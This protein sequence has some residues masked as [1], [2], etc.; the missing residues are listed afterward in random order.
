MLVIFHFTNSLPIIQKLNDIIININRGA[1]E[2]D[3]MPKLFKKYL[4]R[5][6]FN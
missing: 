4:P 5:K 2:N 3:Y 1:H 6:D